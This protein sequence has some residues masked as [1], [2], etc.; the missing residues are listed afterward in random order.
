VK[1]GKVF[2]LDW[3]GERGRLSSFLSRV[4]WGLV[5]WD[6]SLIGPSDWGPFI[7]RLGRDERCM[8]PVGERLGGNSFLRGKKE[9]E[10][11]ENQGR[12][13][14]RVLKAKPYLRGM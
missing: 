7:F 11:K 2:F 10:K 12:E 6:L 13:F 1:K 3:K 9:K 14:L 5:V 4:F 8:F